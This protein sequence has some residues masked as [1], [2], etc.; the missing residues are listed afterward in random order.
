MKKIFSFIS[1]LLL[2]FWIILFYL[3]IANAE[4][5]TK[6]V[7]VVVTYPISDS[8]LWVDA[9][10]LVHEPNSWIIFRF[11]LK[12][13]SWKNLCMEEKSVAVVNWI[14]TYYLGSQYAINS[15][16]VTTWCNMSALINNSTY[17]VVVTWD[18]NK[19]NDFTDTIDYTS[20]EAIW[21][22]SSSQQ[23]EDSFLDSKTLEMQNS[24][25]SWV[26]TW[27]ST[28]SVN[29]SAN[30]LN[31]DLIASWNKTKT[32][33]LDKDGITEVIAKNWSSNWVIYAVNQISNTYENVYSSSNITI[34]DSTNLFVAWKDFNFIIKWSYWTS[35]WVTKTNI[36]S[37][38]IT[39]K[40]WMITETAQVIKEFVYADYFIMTVN[41]V[42]KN[43]KFSSLSR[44]YEEQLAITYG[45]ISDLYDSVTDSSWSW[46]PFSTD[47]VDYYWGDVRE[48]YINWTNIIDVD[49]K[50]LWDFNQDGRLD[51]ITYKNSTGWKAYFTI[52]LRKADWTYK[53]IL[54]SIL[55]DWITAWTSLVDNSIDFWW[56]DINEIIITNW[57]TKNV[58]KINWL[59]ETNLLGDW[60]TNTVKLIASFDSS[61]YAILGKN[62]WTINISEDYL[63]IWNAFTDMDPTMEDDKYLLIWNFKVNK[64]WYD[65]YDYYIKKYNGSEFV[66]LTILGSSIPFKGIGNK[67]WVKQIWSSKFY[68]IYVDHSTHYSKWLQDTTTMYYIKSWKLVP[69]FTNVITNPNNTI[70]SQDWP[71]WEGW[72]KILNWSI[73]GYFNTSIPGIKSWTIGFVSSRFY[74][75]T[76]NILKQHSEGSYNYYLIDKNRNRVNVSSM[77]KLNTIFTKFID[78]N[79]IYFNIS[80][81]YDSVDAVT[82]YSYIKN[83]LYWIWNKESISYKSWV[84]E[85]SHTFY[86]NNG[87]NLWNYISQ[88]EF[89]TNFN[90]LF[91]SFQTL[92]KNMIFSNNLVNTQISDYWTDRE[93]HTVNNLR[94]NSFP[95]V[96]DYLYKDTGFTN[97]W[98]LVGHKLYYVGSDNFIHKWF[99]DAKQTLVDE[100]IYSSSSK[101]LKLVWSK[102][103]F[104]NSS[105]WNSLYY[106][107][108]NNND[109]TTK[110]PWVSNI[111][112]ILNMI[113]TR[114]FM[115]NN[116]NRVYVYDFSTSMWKEITHF[117]VNWYRPKVSTSWTNYY[118]IK[119]KNSYYDTYHYS[120]YL[121]ANLVM[122]SPNTWTQRS[123][124]NYWYYYHSFNFTTSNVM[125]WAWSVFNNATLWF[126]DGYDYKKYNWQVSSNW[127]F[128]IWQE[129]YF[130]NTTDSEKLYK[131]NISNEYN[132]DGSRERAFVDNIHDRKIFDMRAKFPIIISANYEKKLNN[133][134]V[135]NTDNIYFVPWVIYSWDHWKMKPFYDSYWSK[136][137]NKVVWWD[138]NRNS[139]SSNSIAGTL[140]YEASYRQS[141]QNHNL[142]ELWN[143]SYRYYWDSV[144]WCNATADIN[145]QQ[146][147]WPIGGW[148]WKYKW[149]WWY[150]FFPL[151]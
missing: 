66:D 31:N 2:S 7:R 100:I 139:N 95:T 133:Y 38:S 89:V 145:N 9:G 34:E 13:S 74:W 63:S 16:W 118:Y 85:I 113:G 10:W 15:N 144:S 43:F 32:F 25:T 35:A 106:I 99:I 53:V 77:P 76:E 146:K 48:L 96:A 50:I 79:P 126:N 127:A 135:V 20:E 59:W 17:K 148:C 86:N 60:D 128:K 140:N 71:T 93:L 6:K 102:I 12:D 57:N 37:I 104:I 123:S 18:L 125:W 130:A 80:D 112:H 21:I 8:W 36:S 1:I 52:Y 58:Y 45:N 70:S 90:N 121:D 119:F 22:Q 88:T 11:A 64:D 75:W 40:N 108:L 107:D 91:I 54:D 23:F 27:E 117:S 105:D 72:G 29:I 124:F 103:Y 81:I 83:L 62:W 84:D 111:R 149:G 141:L 87:T 30:L 33:D 47:L 73:L 114:F 24:I 94:W 61:F 42:D 82:I 78:S 19:D 69:L 136:R 122:S 97:N 151:Y 49:W 55:W 110:V 116:N 51:V 101:E 131:F 26:W 109:Q 142:T 39:M 134:I 129:L 98:T 138:M 46:T 120:F 56:K 4:L 14:I 65:Y 67:F 41:W 150:K 132:Y 3:N 115:T 92:D 28:T 143:H 137:L 147:W 44:Q 5:V 68:V